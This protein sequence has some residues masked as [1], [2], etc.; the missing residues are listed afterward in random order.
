[1]DPRPGLPIGGARLARSRHAPWVIAALG[2]IVYLLAAPPSADLAAQEYR[3]DLGLRLWNDGWFAGHHVPGYSVL[4][5]PL[6]GSL[7]VPLTGAL[8][9]LIATAAFT[10][11]ARHHW[12]ERSGGAAALWFAAGT[13]AVLLDGR[14]TFLLGVAIGL[15]ALLAL[16]HDRRITALALAATTTLASPVAGLFVALAVAAWTL[17]AARRRLAW[18]LAIGGAA[19]API[20]IMLV[21][22]PEGGSEPFVGSAFWPALGGTLLI[23]ALLPA[24]ERTLR[25]G[26]LLYAVVLVG[27][28]ALPRRLAAMLRASARSPPGRSCSAPSLAVGTRRSLR[29]LPSRSPTGRCIRPCATWCGRAAIRRCRPPTTRRS[30]ASYSHPGDPVR[31]RPGSFRVEIPLDGESLGST[32]RRAPRCARTWLGAP[33]RP[34][35]RRALLRRQPERARLS[36][37]ARRARG[38]IR[39]RARRAARR[40][41]ARRGAARRQRAALPARGLARR[42]LARVRGPRSDAAGQHA[43]RGRDRGDHRPRRGS[44]AR[45][46]APAPCSCACT[47]RAGGA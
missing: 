19:L 39:R 44:R 24:D 33:A 11:L 18:G 38:R 35:L 20:A 34:P 22:F 16:S 45:R 26:A 3:A 36:R 27:S 32:L 8:A 43:R 31:A 30:C 17:A 12:G 25:S 1:M 29:H 37:L 40:G 6:G 13:I 42:A 28:F 2:A 21:L 41:R 9:A 7:G 10:A 47:S 4:F 14:I 23:A 46:A 15:G 5:P